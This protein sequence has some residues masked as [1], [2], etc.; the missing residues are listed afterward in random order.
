MMG[1]NA[2]PPMPPRLEIVKLPPCICAAAS[3]PAR[4]FSR[5]LAE[6]ARD[7]VDVLAVGVADHRHHQAVGRVGGEADVD[8]LLEIRLS[9]RG[10]ERGVELREL[11]QRLDAG[12]HDEGQRRQLDAGARR[13]RP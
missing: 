4:A 10:I 1:V 6:L 11:L 13:P 7:L 12:A 5:Q 3:L 2:V 8:V 9:P